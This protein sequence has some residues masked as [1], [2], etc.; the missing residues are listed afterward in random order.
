MLLV[1]YIRKTK[2]FS[3]A[4]YCFGQALFTGTD[5]DY[6]TIRHNLAPPVAVYLNQACK[7][8]K[9]QKYKMGEGTPAIHSLKNKMVSSQYF[10]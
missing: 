5:S 1:P 7:A 9:I 8:G 4:W 10:F 2:Q 6:T 3:T